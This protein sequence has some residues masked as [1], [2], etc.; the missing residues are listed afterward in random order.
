[1][2]Y[3]SCNCGNFERILSKN[4]PKIA[5]NSF[6][7]NYPV[8]I[9]DNFRVFREEMMLKSQKILQIFLKNSMILELRRILKSF[10]NESIQNWTKSFKKKFLKSKLSWSVITENID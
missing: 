4:N 8:L 3:I 9:K 7:I 2:N 5:E 6:K 1:M 10:A